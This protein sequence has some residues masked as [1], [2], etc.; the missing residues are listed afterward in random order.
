[1]STIHARGAKTGVWP[2]VLTPYAD[3]LSIDWPALDALIDW[4][5][6]GGV[7]GLFAVC[8][9]S[10]MYHLTDGERLQMARRVARRVG[11]RVPV[12]AS[13]TFGGDLNQQTD[14]V[15]RTYDTGVAA[16]VL[17]VSQ[18]ASEAEDD[19]AWKAN[20]SRLLEATPDVPLGLYECPLPYHRLL[21]AESF[22]WL[23][24]T[25][26]FVF[27]KD[28]SCRIGP[29][30]DK[31]EASVDTPLAFYNAHTPTLLESIRAGGSGYCGTAANVYP[32]LLVWLCDQAVS[33]PGR[34][35]SLQ[36]LLGVCDRAVAHKY[37]AHKYHALART[38][39]RD[40][41]LP[42]G[43]RYRADSSP[44][45]EPDLTVLSHLKHLVSRAREELGIAEPTVRP[46]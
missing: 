5:L 36:H 41:G 24:H 12:V 35:E 19:D 15:K 8:L 26:R 27:H 20:V 3:D 38:Y 11:G 23:A 2:V 42:I 17:I 22:G 37:Q 4:Y 28:T 1:L 33:Q 6:A 39:L 45:E 16:V 30:R 43:M 40:L 25:G 13:G 10:D 7:S 31:I 29:M 46:R 18:C 34:A 32:E 21:A 9:S 44:L 14:G